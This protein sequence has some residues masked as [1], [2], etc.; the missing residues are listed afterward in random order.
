MC[1]IKPRLLS[2]GPVRYSE[3][4]N[5]CT[6]R[7]PWSPER[8]CRILDLNVGERLR[9]LGTSLIWKFRSLVWEAHVVCR[10]GPFLLTL[11]HWCS[12][13][14]GLRMCVFE[15]VEENKHEFTMFN[16]KFW[17]FLVLFRSC[18]GNIEMFLML[19]CLLFLVTVRLLCCLEHVCYVIIMFVMFVMLVWGLDV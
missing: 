7:N 13:L 12:V 6:T 5:S 18:L 14:A 9:T 8:M 17:W 4:K 19:R 11:M 15:D 1:R 3:W 10:G 2:S 16:D